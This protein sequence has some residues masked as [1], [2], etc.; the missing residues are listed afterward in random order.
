[1]LSLTLKAFN[2]FIQTL[3]NDC[4]HTEDVHLLLSAYFTFFFLIL[5]RVEHF[6]IG[7]AYG[8]PSLCNL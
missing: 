3:H 2:P 5:R 8:V 7:N 1:M 6:S 4:S